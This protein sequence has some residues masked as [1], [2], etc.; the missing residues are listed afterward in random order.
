MLTI[1]HSRLPVA[2]VQQMSNKHAKAEIRRLSTQKRDRPNALEN[3]LGGTD[4]PEIAG[5]AERDMAAERRDAVLGHET[6]A[7][8][9]YQAIR[10]RI[11]LCQLPPGSLVNERTLM[12]EISFGRTPVR[13]ALLRLAAEQ[14]VVFS[15]QSIQVAP[16]TVENI[17]ALYTARLHAERLAWRLWIASAN[18]QQI[19]RLS[20]VFETAPGLAQ[21]GDEEGLF[22]L[23]FRFHS[24]V[25]RECGNPFLSAHLHNLT[26]L[27][28]RVWFLAN[29]HEIEQH[30]LTVR[31]HDPIID[32]VAARD[33]AALD[34]EVA[35]HIGN[36]FHTVI[37]RLKGH[38]LTVASEMTLNLLE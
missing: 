30:F 34:R 37:Q 5:Q 38:T 25:Y 21:C 7:S 19:A 15:G 9:A 10:H 26:G 20:A 1:Y 32:A 22:D 8:R 27:T 18:A 14:L 28:F 24:Q 29:P 36:A 13:E 12:E 3:I 4:L 33:A 35:A 16:V 2:R 6:D 23:D 31:S 17:S 11:L